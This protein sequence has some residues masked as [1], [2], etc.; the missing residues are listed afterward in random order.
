MKDSI[1]RIFHNLSESVTNRRKAKRIILVR[2]GQ[3]KA[4]LNDL[5]YSEVPDN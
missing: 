2:H 4:N 3:S 5:V 1:Y